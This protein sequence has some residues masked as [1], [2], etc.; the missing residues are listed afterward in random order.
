MCAPRASA[1]SRLSRTTTPAPS[2]M[3][4]PSRPASNGRDALVGLSLYLD[5]IAFM[6]PKPATPTCVTAASVPPQIMTS[7]APRRII[8]SESP[9]ACAPV[10][11]AVT[12]VEFGPFAPVIME[13]WPDAISAIIIGM[14]NGEILDG[15]LSTNTL[16]WSSRVR[17]PPMPLPTRTPTRSAF[18]GVIFSPASSIASRAAATPKWTKRSILRLSLRSI[19]LVTSKP[20]T[21]AAIWTSKSVGS[22]CVILPIP[23][24]PEIREFQ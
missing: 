13:I 22:K 19:H 5:V 23:E 21:S 11:H 6:L 16:H 24:T 18:A 15:P 12:T 7:A 9:S 2:P 20:L 4:K 1:C 17:S 14:R 3:T 10:A 8:S